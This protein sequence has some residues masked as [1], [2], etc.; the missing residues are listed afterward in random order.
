MDTWLSFA[1][2]LALFPS[3]PFFEGG[4]HA[5]MSSD[6][7]EKPE[8]TAAAAVE[9][10][11]HSLALSPLVGAGLIASSAEEGAAMVPGRNSS[12]YKV[13]KLLIL[14]TYSLLINTSAFDITKVSN[15]RGHQK[16]QGCSKRWR[17]GCV[18]MR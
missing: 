13:F 3:F 6:Q 2:S 4:P 1:P 12:I 15:F 11:Q 18:K 16:I 7:A 10:R 17:Q 9:P 8:D 14:L 5:P